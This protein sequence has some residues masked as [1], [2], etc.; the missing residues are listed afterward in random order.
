MRNRRRVAETVAALCVASSFVG[1]V[2]AAA[3]E[4]VYPLSGRYG[5]A[6]HKQGARH[7]CRQ[8]SPECVVCRTDM[9]SRAALAS[10][11]PYRL[12]QRPEAVSDY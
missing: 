8:L 7:G 10:P 4:P 3:P 1:L 5:L 2:A 11:R 9:Q 12:F 6:A